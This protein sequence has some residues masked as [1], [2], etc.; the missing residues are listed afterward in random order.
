MI[1]IGKVKK[2]RRHLY[3]GV[4]FFGIWQDWFFTLKMRLLAICLIL[5]VLLV[6]SVYAKYDTIKVISYK[7]ANPYWKYGAW[8]EVGGNIIINGYDDE[9]EYRK[10]LSHEIRHHLCWKWTGSIYCNDKD[11]K[12]EHMEANEKYG[13]KNMKK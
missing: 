10:K 12:Q 9:K 3:K 8:Y 7:N 6:S 4:N 11:W 2:K 1:F 5:S 13:L